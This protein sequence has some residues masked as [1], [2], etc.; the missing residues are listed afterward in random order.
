[1][2]T[3][4]EFQKLHDMLPLED[5]SIIHF[6][7]GS[8]HRTQQNS[9][10]VEFYDNNQKNLFIPYGEHA[11][12]SG[13]FCHTYSDV[14]S[15]LDNPPKG[16]TRV[17]IQVWYSHNGNYIDAELWLKLWRGEWIT[18]SYEVL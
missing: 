3:I 14:Q 5:T 18:E 8:K 15:L 17:F 16:S 6:A 4:K 11:R 2:T 12:I 13:L 7:D 1:M 9:Y 10:H